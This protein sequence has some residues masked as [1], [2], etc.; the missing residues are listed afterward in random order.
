MVCV[1][2]RKFSGFKS[3][4]NFNS[5]CKILTVGKILMN[6]SLSVV[7]S[8]QNLFFNDCFLVGNWKSLEIT[9]S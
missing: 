2:F 5:I 1:D 3:P 8:L 4:L 7:E 6:N 9:F